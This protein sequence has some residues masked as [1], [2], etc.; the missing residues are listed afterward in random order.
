MREKPLII[1]TDGTVLLFVDAPG[2]REVRA[3]LSLF[4]EL[5]KS[6]EYVHTYRITPISLWNAAAMGISPQS[7][8]DFL[9]ENS[10]YEVP[11]AIVK[12]IQTYME[13]YGKA[14]LI[15]KEGKL[16]LVLEDP[17]ISFL[18]FSDRRARQFVEDVVS[19]ADLVIKKYARGHLKL[20]LVKMG[21]PVEDWAG[22]SPGEP[23]H[24]TLKETLKLRPYQVEAVEAFH[25]GG[26]ERGGSGIVVLPCGA[27]KTVVGIGVMEKLQ[28]QTL[29]VVTSTV[30]ARQWKE[31]LLRWTNIPREDIGEYSGER[32]EIRP[33][34]I[35]TYNILVHRRKREGNFSHLDLFSSRNWGLVIYDEVHLLPAPVFKITAD[36]QAK[37]RLG[38][39]A[40]LVREDGR[41]E[42]IFALVG[43]KKY[44][45]PWKSFEE[46]GWIA[47]ARCFEVRV[48]M[49]LELKIEYLKASRR[50]K[51]T[52]A[53]TN[54][55]KIEALLKILKRHRK[56]KVLIIG[57]F[58]NQLRE[59]ATRL[60]APLIT[61]TTPNSER[62]KLY[63]NFRR[64]E[65][66]LLVV[67]KV[68][69]FAINLPS[70]NVAIEIS[71]TFGSRQEEAQRLGRILRPKGEG[72]AYFYA[73]VSAET[74]D[75]EYS[76][77]RQIFLTEQGYNY[78][79]ISLEELDEE[80][81]LSGVL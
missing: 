31:E 16:H 70:A 1:Q 75:E 79:I 64:G 58:I 35:A 80:G 42:E 26:S 69:N 53:S 73:I 68:A 34:T 36:I 74:V 8:L 27:G 4:A 39:S 14:R 47:R 44:D 49:P 38:L 2:F 52:L 11:A 25:S 13:R 9:R 66:N 60:K 41:E 72:E 12:K 63:E 17:S 19:E 37:R 10:L 65:I 32:K 23:Y 30:A 6:P 15:M 3:E 51:F 62:E 81:S 76:A 21:Y 78:T 28:T 22:Y 50:K 56:D 55:K 57:Q 48:P 33:I 20:F 71:G 59:V 43:P 7:I 18:I 46:M 29:V 5:V 45:A 61:G 67:S 77:K 40:T 24:F 54:P